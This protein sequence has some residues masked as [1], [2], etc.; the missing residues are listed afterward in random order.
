MKRN[1]IKELEAMGVRRA[2]KP[3]VGSVKL[4]HLKF[5][6]LADILAKVKAERGETEKVEET[7]TEA[8]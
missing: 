1:L 7:K 5:P 3:G 2:E 4:S 6:Y 8:E